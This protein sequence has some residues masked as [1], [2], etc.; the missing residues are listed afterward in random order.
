MESHLQSEIRLISPTESFSLIWHVRNW[1]SA[2][3]RYDHFTSFNCMAMK[4][5]RFLSFILSSSIIY[6]LCML[7][8]LHLVKVKGITLI[9]INVNN[10]IQWVGVKVVLNNFTC[11]LGKSKCNRPDIYPEGVF[12]CFR[13]SKR[14]FRSLTYRFRSLLTLFSLT[15]CHYKVHKG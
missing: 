10:A 4:K 3:K 14:S 6:H 12:V 11:F 15:I 7:L 1:A 8:T 13:G 9:L 2:S 5:E